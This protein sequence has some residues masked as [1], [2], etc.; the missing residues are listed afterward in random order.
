[1]VNR[2]QVGR[3]IN[4]MCNHVC[5]KGKH[6]W[7]CCSLTFLL[8]GSWVS[9]FKQN[10]DRHLQQLMYKVWCRSSDP[11]R[12]SRSPSMMKTHNCWNGKHRLRRTVCGPKSHFSAQR[13]EVRS[14]QFTA[15]IVRQGP[16]TQPYCDKNVQNK[17]EYSCTGGAKSEGIQLGFP[18]KK[19]YLI[20]VSINER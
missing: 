3:K 14:V 16:R 19:V 15:H 7:N 13:K 5:K 2:T 8:S 17:Y 4:Y 11:H 18:E 6:S 9:S 12:V 20:C 10:S 1:M